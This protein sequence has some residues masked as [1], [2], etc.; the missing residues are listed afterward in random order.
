VQRAREKL[1]R[2]GADLIV[3]NDVSRAEIG[4]DS[5]DNEVLIVGPDDEVGVPLAPKPQVADAILDRVE[6]MRTAEQV[7]DGG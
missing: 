2:K 7:A 5:E 6:A 3:F 4:F 1:T